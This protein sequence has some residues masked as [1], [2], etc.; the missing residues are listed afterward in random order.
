MNTFQ[1]SPGIRKAIY[2]VAALCMSAAAALGFIDANTA[3]DF[4]SGFAPVLEG[5]AGLLSIFSLIM[6]TLKTHAD[7]DV[8]RFDVEKEVAERMEAYTNALHEQM[9]SVAK[10]AADETLQNIDPNKFLPAD[11]NPRHELAVNNMLEYY[12]TH[13]NN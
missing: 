11:Y 9:E 3:G 1:V 10:K 5:S 4:L 2:M 12:K 13:G 7:S 6:A 8:S